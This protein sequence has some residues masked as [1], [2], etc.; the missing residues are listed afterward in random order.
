MVRHTPAGRDYSCGEASHSQVCAGRHTPYSWPNGPQGTSWHGTSTILARHGWHEHVWH[1]WHSVPCH[2]SARADLQV[3]ARL[4][5]VLGVL[6]RASD[7]TCQSKARRAR[8]HAGPSR[9]DLPVTLLQIT[10]SKIMFIKGIRR[11]F[12]LQQSQISKE[13]QTLL[14]LFEVLPQ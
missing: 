11:Q 5:E 3:R 8:K 2:A 6:C 1:G 7:T 14:E 10:T 9:H 12:K 4:L 13:Y